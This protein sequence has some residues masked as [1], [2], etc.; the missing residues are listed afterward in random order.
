MSLSG[1]RRR[2]KPPVGTILDRSSALALGL[3]GFYPLNE[4]TGGTISDATGNLALATTGFGSANPWGAGPAGPGLLCTASSA[5]AYAVPT[6]AQQSLAATWPVTVAA[7]ATFVATPVSNTNYIPF[8]GFT[9]STDGSTTSYGMGMI[10]V[11]KTGGWYLD[12]N[13]GT[14]SEAYISGG[15][16]T[17]GAPVVV[18]GTITP[19]G[20]NLYVNGQPVASSSTANTPGLFGPTPRLGFA[21][22]QGRN[23]NAIYYWGAWWNR[24]LSVD[25]HAAIGP[26][27]NAIWRVFRPRYEATRKWATAGG[28]I[29]Y[30]RGSSI[31]RPIHLPTADMAAC[32]E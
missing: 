18:A 31:L 25:E 13:R 19:S 22:T 16:W 30:P 14:T 21:T 5:A 3:Q 15:S 32:L 17:I 2:Q 24:A 8:F 26:D 6:A 10:W 20:A 1:S 28:W 7:A 23:A 4:G 9:Y 27:P 12:W 29:P 11:N